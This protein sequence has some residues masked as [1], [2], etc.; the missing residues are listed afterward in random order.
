[1]PYVG[2]WVQVLTKEPTVSA[3]RVDQYFL[4]Y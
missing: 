2:R 1:M 3:F 4:F